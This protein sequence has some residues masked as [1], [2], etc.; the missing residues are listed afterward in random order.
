MYN[1]NYPYFIDQ[2]AKIEELR[3]LIRLPLLSAYC[4]LKVYPWFSLLFTFVLTI[5]L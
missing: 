2:E 1:F 4:H 5:L 3:N